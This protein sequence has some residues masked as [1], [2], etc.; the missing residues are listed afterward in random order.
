[1][2]SQIL[3]DELFYTVSIEPSR[4][5]VALLKLRIRKASKTNLRVVSIEQEEQHNNSIVYRAVFL[6]Y[7]KWYCVEHMRYKYLTLAVRI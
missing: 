4:L 2:I 7:E 1:M 3:V 5:G 6:I